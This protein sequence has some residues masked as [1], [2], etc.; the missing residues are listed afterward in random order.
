MLVESL[1]VGTFEVN[2]YLLACPETKKGIV[3]DPGDEVQ[4][5]LEKIGQMNI[6]IEKIILTHGHPDH[7]SGA[8]ALK[9][10]TGAPIMMHKSDVAT[11]NDRLLRMLL[12]MPEGTKIEPDGLIDEGDKI[13]V[14]SI[15]LE[16]LHTPGHSRGSIC[17]S[18]DGVLFS[19]DLLFAGGIGRCDLP[20]GNEKQ[21]IES[22]KKVTQM[23]P[24]IIVYP[25]HGPFT[26][27]EAE[28]RGN[29]YLNG[30]I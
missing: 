19:G 17:L 26:T 29:N 8:N 9:E 6:N 15:E 14:G 5:I 28:S 12:G 27:I 11:A 23:D 7:S 3:I 16:V 25:G 4:R 21:M 13:S 10:A 30:W 22:L 2:C 20:G 1:V 18:G 24:E